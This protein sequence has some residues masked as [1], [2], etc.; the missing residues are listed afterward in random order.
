MRKYLIYFMRDKL[1][2]IFFSILNKMQK[3][4]YIILKFSDS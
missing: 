1:S 3:L 4:H 2:N